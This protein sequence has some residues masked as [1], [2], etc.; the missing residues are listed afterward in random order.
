MEHLAQKYEIAIWSAI[1]ANRSG[2]SKPIELDNVSGSIAKVQKASMVLALT[3]TPIQ[4][5]QNLADVRVLKNRTGRKAQT[6]N[7]PWNPSTMEIAMPI[8]QDV[9]L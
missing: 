7:C 5:E 9:L 4:E 1:Q 2:I 6:I 3:R 8:C